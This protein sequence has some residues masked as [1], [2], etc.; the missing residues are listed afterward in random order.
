MWKV[1]VN[2]QIFPRATYCQSFQFLGATSSR[3]VV[4]ILKIQDGCNPVS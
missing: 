2:H 4:V 1:R 3:Y